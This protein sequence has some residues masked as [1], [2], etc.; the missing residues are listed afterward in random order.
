MAAYMHVTDRLARAVLSVGVSLVALLAQEE[1]RVFVEVL[2]PESAYLSQPVEVVVTLGYDEA[3]FAEHGVA[4]FRQQVDAPFHVAIPW[5]LPDA[6]HTVVFVAP[7][8]ESGLMRVAVGDRIVSAVRLPPSERA[9]RTFTLLRLRCRWLPLAAG[10]SSIAP[11]RV[12]F[13]Y[14]DEFRD[15]LLRGR[16]P[17][18][19]KQ[20]EVVSAAGR[21]EVA[22]LPGDAPAAWHGAVGDYSVD[23]TSGG[24]RIHVGESF[25][26][27]VT[28][29]GDGN[30][31]QFST[32]RPPSI[33]GFHVLGV[34]ERRL[35]GSRL[36]IL[37]VLA[38]R[39]GLNEMPGISFVAFSPTAK[40]YVTT[41]SASV[42]VTVL[43]Q[44]E[45]VAVSQQIQELI[46][47]DRASRDSD[48]ARSPLRW[49]FVVLAVLGLVLQR[50]HVQRKGNRSIANAVEQLRLALSQDADPDNVATAFEVVMVRVAGGGAF[51]APGVWQDLQARGVAPEGLRQLQSLHAQLDAAR[52]G[53]P[54]P[55]LNAVM[56][57]VETLVSSS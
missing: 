24:E 35:L 49:A 12:R 6:E 36:F 38:L 46:D 2:Y 47:E 29:Q 15:N 51:S 20:I 23:A 39:P 40:Q 8:E 17:V 10:I 50:R 33:D 19:Q 41:K 31:E 25:Q 14:A 55:K 22:T 18:D 54:V 28:I 44:R 53:G 32:L 45:D 21:L 56:G 1:D 43:A 11:V 57:P 30:Y 48:D 4:L 52:F 42:P 37:D 27:E 16:E 13:A 5:A 3:W 34:V 9:G 26:V 7:K